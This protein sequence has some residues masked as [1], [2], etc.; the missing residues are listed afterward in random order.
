MPAEIVAGRPRLLLALGRLRERQGRFPEAFD[1]L[2]QA[3]QA[4]QAAADLEQAYRWQAWILFRQDRYVEAI[5]L[6]Q[7]ALAILHDKVDTVLPDALS[8]DVAAPNWSAPDEPM[9]P[10]RGAELAAVYNILA[11]CY[12]SLGESRRGQEYFLRALELF[13][14]LGNREREA[15]VLHN[16]ATNYLPQGLLRETLSTE[17]T[18]LCILE[19]LNSYRICFPLITLGQ[20]YLQ[21]G[22]LAAART[23]LE[24]LLRLTDT[25]QDVPR[26]GYALYLLGHLHRAQGDRTAAR[27]CYQEAWLIAEQIQER[28]LYFE[29]GQGLAR[30]AMDDGDLREARRQGLAADLGGFRPDIF[31]L[32]V[33]LLDG[34]GRIQGALTLTGLLHGH[35][36]AQIQSW[37]QLLV[38]KAAELKRRSKTPRV[39]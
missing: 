25:Y 35:S 1:L 22:D 26:R 21:R 28:F 39:A 34:D 3:E 27:S 38:K 29:L 33:P 16:M 4:S 20:T 19:E 10:T 6:C 30:L 23:V 31:G 36:D 17:Q 5:A 37:R 14:S 12:S 7:R 32:S 9:D 24:R 2:A 13:R 15:V 18:S 11:S 8:P